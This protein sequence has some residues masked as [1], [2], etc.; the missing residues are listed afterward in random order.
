[1]SGRMKGKDQSIKMMESVQKWFG[2]L[3]SLV[4]GL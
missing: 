4:V 1:M 3:A 2:F